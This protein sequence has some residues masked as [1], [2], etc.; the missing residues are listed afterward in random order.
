LLAC[1]EA[2]YPYAIE[3]FG[4]VQEHYACVPKIPGYSSNQLGQLQGRTMSGSKTKLLIPQQ[5]T[6]VYFIYDS[7][8]QDIFKQ[9]ANRVQQTRGSVG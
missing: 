3:G 8:K 9:F 4:H 5:P 6:L 7:S 1:K 2:I